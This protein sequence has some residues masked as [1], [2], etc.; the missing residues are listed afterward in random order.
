MPSVKTAVQVAWELDD[1]SKE[2][3]IAALTTLAQKDKKIDHF[4]II[5]WNQEETI[6]ANEIQIQVKPLYKFLLAAEK[7]NY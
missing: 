5:T 4:E 3:E 2:R 1:F 6:E 7:H